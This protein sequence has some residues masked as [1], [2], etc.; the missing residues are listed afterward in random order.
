MLRI[1]K[2]RQGASL[3]VA[4]LDRIALRPANKTRQ[5]Q[6]RRNPR[7]PMRHHI[8]HRI[9]WNVRTEQPFRDP[10]GLC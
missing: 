9:D 4:F 7:R 5:K 8:H 6:A 10:A 1:A 2:R 3:E